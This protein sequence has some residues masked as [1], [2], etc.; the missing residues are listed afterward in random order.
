LRIRYWAAFA[1]TLGTAAFVD[2]SSELLSNAGLL[3]GVALPDQHQEAVVPV[4]LMAAMLSFGLAATIAL[5]AVR[6]DRVHYEAGSLRERLLLG[7]A[8]LAAT[9]A[10]IVLMEAFEMRFGGISAF[11]PRSVLAEHAPALLAGYALVSTLVGSV[12]D[13]CLRLAEVGG[14]LVADAAGRFHRCTKHES[15]PLRCEAGFDSCG[16]FGTSLVTLGSVAL[17]APPLARVSA[18]LPIV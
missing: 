9:L 18:L 7:F 15:A 6:G 1:T 5:R 2:W 14:A 17:R 16:A 8:T 12:V 4:A 13:A 3:G 10:T 11:D